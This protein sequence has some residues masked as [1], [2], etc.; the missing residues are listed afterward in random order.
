M[1]R[2]DVLGLLITEP[3]MKYISSSLVQDVGSA[4]FVL[5]G[6][7]DGLSGLGLPLRE[8]ADKEK[9]VELLDTARSFMFYLSGIGCH[10]AED[11]MVSLRSGGSYDLEWPNAKTSY[12]YHNQTGALVR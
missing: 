2:L 5:D 11:K 8:E 7:L 6:I 3:V 9:L 4:A 1:D 12:A 10:R